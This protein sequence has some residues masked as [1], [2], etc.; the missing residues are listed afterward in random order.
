MLD[1]LISV[2]KKGDWR[3][4][5]RLLHEQ[6]SQQCPLIF[7]PNES[8]PWDVKIDETKINDILL[9]PVA[10]AYC[11]DENVGSDLKPLM[12]SCGLKGD[13]NRPGNICGRVFK[14]GEATYSCKECAS[15]PTCVLCYQCFQKSAHRFHKYRIENFDCFIGF[16]RQ[17]IVDL[18]SEEE[19]KGAEKQW[20]KAGCC[21]H[22]GNSVIVEKSGSDELDRP[23]MPAEIKYDD[24][25]VE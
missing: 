12:V 15:D 23:L 1:K 18:R 8:A 24:Y 11:L 4:A 25:G 2:A 19:R 9:H 13:E 10:T 14:C 6:W 21:R 5:E 7:A 16:L 22:L 3:E 20:I 17:P